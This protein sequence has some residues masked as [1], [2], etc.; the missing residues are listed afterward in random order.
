MVSSMPSSG[1]NR[2]LSITPSSDP[3]I[4][5]TERLRRHGLDV[6]SEDPYQI[7]LLLDIPHTYECTAS[8]LEIVDS[9]VE[10]VSK[11][12]RTM[13]FCNSHGPLKDCHGHVLI[14][15]L[16]DGETSLAIYNTLYNKLTYVQE[17]LTGEEMLGE[18]EEKEREYA[19]S[20]KNYSESWI[21][22][23]WAETSGE[24]SARAWLASAL[25]SRW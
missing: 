3:V 23:G 17:I 15:I 2:R 13:E 12:L 24:P 9:M 11:R 22:C 20:G 16:T 4:L 7:Y 21:E 25:I 8:A 5:R 6:G 19:A 14:R 10:E 1:P 18:T